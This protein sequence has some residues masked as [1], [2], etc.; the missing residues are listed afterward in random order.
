MSFSAL[1][2]KV[3]FL[4]FASP[5]TMRLFADPPAERAGRAVAPRKGVTRYFLIGGPPLRTGVFQLTVACALPGSATG[6]R[7]A[8]GTV[9]FAVVQMLAWLVSTVSVA[10]PGPGPG[11]MTKQ[12]SGAAG[13]PGS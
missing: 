7:G 9:A 12:G 10:S 13:S 8:V 3:Y 2:L 6:D 1:T 11:A 5:F 4:L